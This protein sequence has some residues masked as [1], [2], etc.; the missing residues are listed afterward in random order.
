MEGTGAISSD[1]LYTAALT[2]LQATRTSADKRDRDEQRTETL[3]QENKS[4]FDMHEKEENW[5]W[6]KAETVTEKS[7]VREKT[8]LT[9]ANS[10]TLAVKK[11]GP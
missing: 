7:H 6:M 8:M 3:F 2:H 4:L 10:Y 5:E 11:S 9:K 1:T